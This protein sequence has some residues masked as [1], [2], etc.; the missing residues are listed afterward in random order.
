[1]AEKFPFLS[2]ILLTL[3]LPQDYKIK[4][5]QVAD[6]TE[7]TE[8]LSHKNFHYAEAVLSN[9]SGKNIF[10]CEEEDFYGLNIREVMEI[11]TALFSIL[12]LQKTGLYD[13]YTRRLDTENDLLYVKR[14]LPYYSPFIVKFEID[15]PGK[16]FYLYQVLSQNLIEDALKEFNNVFRYLKIP[17]EFLNS[18]GLSTFEKFDDLLGTL[19]WFCFP[20]LEKIPGE[21][22]K[23]R[24]ILIELKSMVNSMLPKYFNMI[25]TM[26]IILSNSEHMF[27]TMLFFPEL[28]RKVIEQIYDKTIIL[29]PVECEIL[30]S[31]ALLK[32]D[33]GF[34]TGV[35]NGFGTVFF[36]F[37]PKDTRKLLKRL[38]FDFEILIEKFLSLTLWFL[39]E[40]KRTLGINKSLFL[41]FDNYDPK[42]DKLWVKTI[43]K[44]TIGNWESIYFR[45]YTS[46]NFFKMLHGEIFPAAKSRN[47]FHLFDINWF[48][49]R[50]SVSDMKFQQVAGFSVEKPLR[51]VSRKPSLKGE[52]ISINEFLR[53]NE[54][55]LRL[56]IQEFI[57]KNGIKKLAL[58]FSNA[59]DELRIKLF[60][61]LSKNACQQFIKA[62]QQKPES[63]V[64]VT[65]SKRDSINVLF[66]LYSEKK[67]NLPVNLKRLYAALKNVEDKR[68]VIETEL[69]L[70]SRLFENL[71]NELTDIQVQLLLRKTDRNTILRAVHNIKE[72]IRNKIFQNMS[73]KAKEIILQDYRHWLKENSNPILR[74]VK[75][76]EARRAIMELSC[77]ITGNVS[78]KTMLDYYFS[79]NRYYASGDFDK[80]IDMCEKAIK[81]QKNARFEINSMF[82]GLPAWIYAFQGK[83]LD[84]AYNLAARALE[85]S[86]TDSEK[87]FHLDTLGWILYKKGNTKEA[88][89]KLK[90]A[91]EYSKEG[92]YVKEHLNLIQP[93]TLF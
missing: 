93:D 12:L 39:P 64:E 65:M 84:K 79:I 4:S 27:F 8:L 75:T 55:S 62:L 1:M 36:A 13:V 11:E 22:D 14:L 91:E 44:L 37:F 33:S 10:L 51:R 23:N 83:E 59:T 46:P 70:K 3:G 47:V 29:K 88:L 60:E 43:Y 92:I 82:F 40:N 52:Q 80:V 63:V 25:E 41:N 58:A 87:C 6:L 9:I 45:G 77:Q 20:T 17:E 53:L 32:E 73:E 72:E 31:A 34:V 24:E 2:G 16:N 30:D 7:F 66:K 71:I 61:N 50:E 76:G 21:I 74:T 78:A 5:V 35:S 68:T 28:C 19:I 57:K 89:I 86:K 56:F 90:E 85:V 26:R 18:I 81:L 15:H 69:I 54:I 48:S 38:D 42:D 49:G 67:I